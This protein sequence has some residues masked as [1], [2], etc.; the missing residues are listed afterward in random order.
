M[1]SSPDAWIGIYSGTS[2]TPP[3]SYLDYTWYQY[4]GDTG[5]TGA[6]GDY[7]DPVISYGTSTAAATEPATWYS[8]PTSISYSAGNFIWQKTEYTLHNA[9]TVQSVDKHIIGY[10][11]QNGSGSGTVTQIT[12]NGTVCQDDGTGNVDINVDATDIG[13]IENP[14][15]KSDGQVLTYDSNADEWVAANPATGNVNTVNNVGVSAGTTNIQLYGTDIPLSSGDSTPVTSAIPSLPLSIAN[16]GTGATTAAA[17]ITALGLHLTEN[18]TDKILELDSTWKLGY[19]NGIFAPYTSDVLAEAAAMTTASVRFYRGSGDSYTG[20]L[21]SGGN[22]GYGSFIVFMRSANIRQVIA[23]PIVPGYGLALNEYDGS[24][25]SGWKREYD[26]LLVEDV[27]SGNVGVPANSHATANI[28][29]SKT[30]YTAMGVVG[31][32]WSGS[33]WPAL[34][35]YKLTSATNVALYLINYTSSAMSNLTYKVSVLYRKNP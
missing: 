5:A 12:F 21:P 19:G 30:G 8:S 26:A 35:G 2:D 16:G 7:I 1:K 4:K 11:G 15:T 29:V 9:Q 34:A 33:S 10:I 20:T 28:N 13:A 31:V 22:Y 14:S 24:S 18:T 6:T 3:T 23:V 17:A 27:N 32:T 25:W